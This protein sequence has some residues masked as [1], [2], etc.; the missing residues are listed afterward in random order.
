MGLLPQSGTNGK[1]IDTGKIACR[2]TQ[3]RGA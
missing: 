2:E 1:K 3:E